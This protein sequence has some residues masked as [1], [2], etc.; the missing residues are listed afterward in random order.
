MAHKIQKAEYFYINVKDEPGSAYNLLN[1]L[2]QLGIN[3]LAFVAVPTGPAN[4]QLTIFPYDPDQL[5]SQAKSAGLEL[6]GPH[7]A[8]LVQ[9]D[10]ELGAL[11]YIHNRLFMANVNVYASMGVADGKGGFGYVVYVRPNHFDRALR[12]LNL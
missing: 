10:D 7:P 11:E 5:I 8:I 2:A 4:T 12:A 1:Q 3:Q 6:D 9:G